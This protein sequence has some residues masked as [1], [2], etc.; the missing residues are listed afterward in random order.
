M[1]KG[2]VTVMKLIFVREIQRYPSGITIDNESNESAEPSQII[3]TD[4]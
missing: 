3:S 1:I 2:Q 4:Q